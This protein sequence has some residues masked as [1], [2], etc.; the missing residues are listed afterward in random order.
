[1][2][3]INFTCDSCGREVYGCTFVNGMKFCAK[4]YQETF[5]ASKD[6]QLLDKYKTI[7]DLEAKLAESEEKAKRY[8]KWSEYVENRFSQLKQQLAEKE[9]EL[10]EINREF[11][12]AIK[13]WK[14]LVAE[15]ENTITTLIED[16]K[17]SKELLKKQLAEKEKEIR[18]FE[19]REKARLFKVDQ[20]DKIELLE[21]VRTQVA[22]L[23]VIGFPEYSCS[24]G[25]ESCQY[26]VDDIIDTL[27]KNISEGKE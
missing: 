10:E 23:E 27:I 26:R 9:K 24:D 1:M 18:G 7:A 2:S 6:W 17:T 13:D 14:A 4:C 15:K 19:A 20:Q 8:E 12:Q 3:S 22:Q 11:V 5:G 16:S 21:K 25:F